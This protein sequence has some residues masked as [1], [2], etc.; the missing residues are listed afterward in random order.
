M[1]SAKRHVRV[2]AESD[3]K[4]DMVECPRWVKSGHELQHSNKTR[5]ST[6]R[7]GRTCSAPA[8]AMFAADPNRTSAEW[9]NYLFRIVRKKVSISP[10]PLI[11]IAP[12]GSK[13]KLFLSIFLVVSET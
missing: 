8:P 2:T 1:C 5:T 7:G 4:C 9:H 10:L 6:T 13:V 12:R 11:S 3:M